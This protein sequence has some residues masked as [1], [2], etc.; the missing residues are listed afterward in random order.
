VFG[1]NGGGGGCFDYEKDHAAFPGMPMFAS[2]HPHTLQTRGVYRTRTWYRDLHRNQGN[3][4]WYQSPRGEA[5]SHDLAP[6]V[7]KDRPLLDL[8]H[9]PDL[10]KEEVFE[11]VDPHYQSSYGNAI[12]RM[13]ILDA[14]YR[15]RTLPYFCGEF[16]WTG[17]DYI[18][19]CYA[20]PA[21]SW[22]FG[23][24]DLCG[25]PKDAYYFCKSQ[26]TRSPMVHILPHWTWPGREGVTIPVLC[27]SNCERVELFL[28]GES[29]GMQAT[30]DRAMQNRWDV[31]Y[32]PGI[33]RAVGYVE[34]AAVAVVEQ[35]TAG[36]P[37]SIRME[38]DEAVIRADRTGIAHVAIT[39]V[40]AQGRFVPHA[41]HD[42]TV[43]VVGPARLIGLENGDPI[44]STNYKLNHR[45]AFNGMLLAI[46]QSTD[47]AG[48][49][50]VSATADGL[51][52]GVCRKIESR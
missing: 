45:K 20:W 49:I 7:Q 33:L 17:F 23:I 8:M 37:A 26:W 4:R 16:R 52:A 36:E 50:A 44:D 28:D 41:G 15:T 51:A 40:D 19:E 48:A 18:G 32:R 9:I 31:P 5:P 24:I 30:D 34:D 21:K 27:Y 2:E 39:I 12:V 42:V 35:Q 14:W 47:T 10:T 43:T 1:Y 6:D 25:F 3:V 11:G 13:S 29:L 46:V 38:S 22:N